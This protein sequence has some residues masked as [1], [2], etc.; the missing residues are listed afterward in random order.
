VTL[1]DITS[2]VSDIY[3]VVA[4]F[5]DVDLLRLIAENPGA[6]YLIIFCGTAF[7]GET[8]VI[9]AGYYAHQGILNLWLLILFASLGSFTGDQAWFFL[10]RRYG[11]LILLRY[12]GW[13]PG[14]ETALSLARR[15]STLYTLTF[16]FI[17]GIR[18]VS[19]FAL[20]MSGLPWPRFMFL[21]AIAAALWATSFAGAGYLFGSASEA[22]LGKVAHNFG[23]VML[24]VFF[25]VV[26]IVVSMHK[27]Q[28][29][30]AA[31]SPAPPP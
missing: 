2:F 28:K 24:L 17:Y 9:F 14:V 7:E 26:W 25:V 1:Q 5:L 13:Q 11:H 23:L 22:A 27:R 18:N 16:R 15:Y 31:E 3:D 6:A 8:F 30:R 12:P 19:S 10:G 20:G 29:R 4:N 21:N